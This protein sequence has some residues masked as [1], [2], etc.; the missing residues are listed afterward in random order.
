VTVVECRDLGL[1]AFVK[2]KGFK[3]LGCEGRVYKFECG[4]SEYRE[5]EIEYANSCCRAHD[6]VVMS[7]RQLQRF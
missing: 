7:L 5:L 2:N 1:A 6:S 3:L 4:E